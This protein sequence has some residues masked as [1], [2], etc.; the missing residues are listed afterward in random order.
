MREPESQGWW[1]AG[2][3]VPLRDPELWALWRERKL[4]CGHSAAREIPQT[5]RGSLLLQKSR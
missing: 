4:V 5:D 2:E 1:C 3:R